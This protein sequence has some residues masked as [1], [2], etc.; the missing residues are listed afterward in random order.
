VP[1]LRS[2]SPPVNRNFCPSPTDVPLDVVPAEVHP[3][4]VEG[5]RNRMPADRQPPPSATACSRWLPAPAVT[6]L[7]PSGKVGMTCSAF[8]APGL[9]EP[10]LSSKYASHS[11][12]QRPQAVAYSITGRTPGELLATEMNMFEIRQ[13][14]Q[15]DAAAV[16]TLDACIQGDDRSATWDMYV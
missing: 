11:R 13:I 6:T 9:V 10:A 5:P 12:R 2:R 3:E 1:R 8:D 7:D 15:D 14:Q 16:R 4:P